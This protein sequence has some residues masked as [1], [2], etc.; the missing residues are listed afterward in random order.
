MSKGV[1]YDGNRCI[2]C[3]SCQVACKSWNENEAE[4][5]TSK[6]VYDNPPHLSARTF[7]MMRFREVEHEG[8]FHWAFAKTQCMHCVHP[9]CVTACPVGALQK[10]RDKGPVVYDDNRCFGCRYCM[11]ACPFGIPTFQW[12]NPLPWIRK[13]SFCADRL[14][15]ELKPACVTACPT[16]AL[17]FGE[18]EELV[19]E[20][21]ERINGSNGKYVDHVYGEKEAGGTSWLYISPVPMEELGFPVLGEEAA[22]ENPHIAMRALPYYAAGVTALMAGFYW[23]TKRRQKL[24]E[25]EQDGQGEKEE[26]TK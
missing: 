2:G 13:C 10:D 16:G 11:V 9:A 5:T 6:G 21:H 18:R 1:L 14:G 24:N 7:T 17:Q 22:T 12:D 23:L 26:V 15:G 19:T 20:A 4:E 8:K 25:A 3:R